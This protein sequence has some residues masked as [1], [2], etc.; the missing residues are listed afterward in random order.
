MSN[1]RLQASILIGLILV[2]FPNV[3]YAYID[4]GTGTF[5]FQLMIAAIAGALFFIKNV[6]VKIGIFIKSVMSKINKE[7]T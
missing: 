3:A 1:N 7:K 4:P 2:L 5:L 6:R